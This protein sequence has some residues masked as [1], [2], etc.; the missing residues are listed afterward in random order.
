MKILKPHE[1]Q[2]TAA[3]FLIQNICA[4]LFLD[5]GLGKTSTTLMVLNGL[6]QCGLPH[7]ALIIAPL[8][9]IYSVWPNEIK[10]WSCFKDLS[11]SL[12]H[13]SPGKRQEALGRNADIYLIN[14]ENVDWLFAQ[15]DLPKWDVL[16]VDESTKFK[17]KSSKRFKILRHFAHTFQRRII[18][19]GTPSPNS[20]LEL[21]SQICLLDNG[22]RLGPFNYYRDSHFRA[23]DWNQYSWNL[24]KGHEKLIS[25]KISDIALRMEA[26]DLLDLPPLIENDILVT[27]PPASMKAYKAL[28]DEMYAELEFLQDR[29]QDDE[30][31]AEEQ[32]DQGRRSSLVASTA[33]VKYGMLRQLAG[34]GIYTESGGVEGS[35]A[36]EAKIEALEELVD[37]LGGKPLLVC[38]HYR[39]E[40][41]R[42][43][44]KWPKT[45]C[46]NGDTTAK[47]VDKLCERWN[48]GE[49]P[50]LFAQPM[51][52]GHGL[53]LQGGGND[54]CWFTPPDSLELY[55]Q[56][57]ARLHR[58][59][60]TGSVRIHRII[61]E[62]TVDL[63]VVS[64][65]SD[66]D[67]Q[68]KSLLEVIKAFRSKDDGQHRPIPQTV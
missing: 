16:V 58:Q 52:M 32:E 29:D 15:K 27:L 6:K 43:L 66:R 65:L 22:K 31:E 19:T 35:T 64:R 48:R 57:N 10:K 40:V 25:D 39:H 5:P 44:K 50:L 34:G 62:G 13:G 12:V 14:P 17:N 49:I 28:E 46:I 67:L 68:Q 38:Y 20:L 4:A 26:K 36:H 59:G 30:F 18:L 3:E 1:Y 42:L 45:P 11:F 53:N 33:A 7:R 60:Q 2:F 47:E 24:K 63:A 55:L 8:R 61:A 41:K 51:S 56:A 23:E 54:L 9:V 21:W 37:G